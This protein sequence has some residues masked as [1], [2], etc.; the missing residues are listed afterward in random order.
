LICPISRNFAQ[1]QSDF[2]I[3]LNDICDIVEDSV[4]ARVLANSIVMQNLNLKGIIIQKETL[5]NLSH[6]VIMFTISFKKVNK[7]HTV[8]NIVLE[9]HQCERS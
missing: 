7:E 8:E 2:T 5:I 3:C 6:Q 4:P 9:K 1:S